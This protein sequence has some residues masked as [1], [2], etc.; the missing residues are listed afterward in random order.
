ML[1]AC[2][3]GLRLLLFCDFALSTAFGLMDTKG[4]ILEMRGIWIFS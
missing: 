3:T 1:E 4:K 2:V